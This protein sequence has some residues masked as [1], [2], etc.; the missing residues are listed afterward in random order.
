[1][2]FVRVKNISTLF[3]ALGPNIITSPPGPGL[4]PPL[5]PLGQVISISP[6]LLTSQPIP[7]QT[8]PEKQR[9]CSAL[10]FLG[11]SANPWEYRCRV[12]LLKWEPFPKSLSPKSPLSVNNIGPLIAL[13]VKVIIII[14]L[15]IGYKYERKRREWG[16]KKR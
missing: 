4:M 7:N 2:V 13:I 12:H 10:Q 3:W 5:G 1:M 8:F 6:H 16:W 11:S 9:H 14:P 15:L